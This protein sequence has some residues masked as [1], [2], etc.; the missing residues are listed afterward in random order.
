[1]PPGSGLR[2]RTTKSSTAVPP[3]HSISIGTGHSTSHPF[4]LAIDDLVV[5]A[6]KPL[7]GGN[8][9]EDLCRSNFARGVATFH[10]DYLFRTDPGWD[11]MATGPFNRPKDNAAPLTGI[12]ETDWLPYPFTMNWQ[13]LRPGRVVFEEDEPFCLIIPIRKQALIGCQPEIRSLSDDPELSRQ[14][15]EFRVARDAFMQRFLAGDAAAIKQA[16]QRYYF[17]GRHPDGT[18]A[19]NH[20]SKLRL[21]DPVDLRCVDAA[22]AASDPCAGADAAGDIETRWS[23]DSALAAMPR[24]PSDANERGR[25]RIGPDGRL[26]DWRGVRMVRSSRDADYCDV[27][28]GEGLLTPDQCETLCQAYRNLSALIVN[29]DRI[30]PYWNNRFIWHADIAAADPEAGD[31]MVDAQE[32][33]LGIMTDF[34]RIEAPLYPD[35]LQIVQ[36]RAGVFMSPHADNANPDG[37]AHEMSHRD[38][39]GVVYLN[40]DYEGGELYFTALDLAIKPRRGM[41]VGMTAGFHHEHAVLRVGSGLRLTMPFFLTFDRAK[42]DRLLVHDGAGSM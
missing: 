38:F 3:F 26:V 22:D 40:D 37:S 6:R 17:L 1:L 31:I 30:D 41:F 35:L 42:A 34:Y 28:V 39:S 5:R 24:G 36:W 19:D 16:W 14:H 13:L 7:P 25:R 2:A 10:L 20:L 27:V 11:L 33:A 18:E 8:A 12:I 23:S 21:L 4:A 32:R 9:V 15:E 29:S